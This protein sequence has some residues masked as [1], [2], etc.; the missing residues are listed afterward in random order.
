MTANWTSVAR[1]LC[2]HLQQNEA[3]FSLL[4]QIDSSI[5]DP[6]APIDKIIENVI[7]ELRQLIQAPRVSVYFDCD[8]YL[9]LLASTNVAQARRLPNPKLEHH[10]RASGHTHLLEGNQSILNSLGVESALLARVYGAEAYPFGYLVVESDD[11]VEVGH[12]RKGDSQ[13]FVSA[14]SKQLS[15]AVEFKE[16]FRLEHV[17][18]GILNDILSSHLKPGIGFGVICRDLA[19]FFP[20]FQALAIQSTQQQ[21]LLYTYPDEYLTVVATT[22]PEDINTR[23]HLDQS[24]SGRLIREEIALLNIDPRDERQLYRPYLGSQMKSELIVRADIAKNVVV[25]VNIESDKENAFRQPH[26]EAIQVAVRQLVPILAGLYARRSRTQLQQRAI[27]YALDNHLESVTEAF[28]HDVNT[29]LATLRELAS[30]IALTVSNLTVNDE[31]LKPLIQGI[32]ERAERLRRLIQG[33]DDRRKQL[34]ND[35]VGFSHNACRSVT[36][37]MDSALQLVRVEDRGIQVSREYDTSAEVY[38]SLFLKEIFANLI[39]NA[40]F[41]L[42][43]RMLDDPLFKGRLSIRITREDRE[44]SLPADSTVAGDRARL[45]QKVRVVVRDNGPGMPAEHS[46]KVFERHFT[47]REDGTGLGLFA[48]KEYVTSIGGEISVNSRQNDFF[49]VTIIL[50]QYDPRLVDADSVLA[51]GDDSASTGWQLPLGY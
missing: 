14:V 36:D 31:H 28:S 3:R 49:E 15:L 24:V 42:D 25:I 18:T 48:A 30:Q 41:W 16:H 43:T 2:A 47:L 22:G 7:H 8:D 45:N 9:D 39:Q 29:P 6:D 11:P 38:S 12:L 32:D 46:G 37:L 26:V 51:V 19:S 33:I 1:Q 40:I 4:Q 50:N 27:L 5:L 17:R 13:D 20:P 10:P 21:I 44:G 23:V 34:V 35:I